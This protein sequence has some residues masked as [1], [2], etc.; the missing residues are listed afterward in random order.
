M[1]V[2][3]TEGSCSRYPGPP[4]YLGTPQISYKGKHGSALAEPEVFF[5][6]P[7]TTFQRV[8]AP[9]R[10]LLRRYML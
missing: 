1:V 8:S 9:L 7:A 4:K 5:A 3:P 2:L 6:A 10:L